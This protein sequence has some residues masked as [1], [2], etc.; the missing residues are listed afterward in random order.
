MA[1]K[2]SKWPT[3][4]QALKATN[5]ASG[6]ASAPPP[7]V[8]GIGLEFRLQAELFSGMKRSPSPLPSPPGR[9]RILPAVGKCSL[10]SDS[11]QRGRNEFPLLGE[12]E[13][14]RAVHVLNCMDWASGGRR[15]S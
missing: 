4:R 5:L 6:P 11:F 15:N 7:R 13:R 1:Q 2:L 12:R 3:A 14:V 10:F 8:R 9:G